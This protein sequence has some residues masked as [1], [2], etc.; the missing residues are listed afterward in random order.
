MEQ[1]PVEE[2]VEAQAGEL[3]VVLVAEQAAAP[4]QVVVRVAG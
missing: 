2:L 4:E 1:A 3:A